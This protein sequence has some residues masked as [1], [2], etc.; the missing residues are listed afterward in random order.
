VASGTEARPAP[1]KVD[2][3]A[4][5]RRAL[6]GTG[7][8]TTEVS[9][10]PRVFERIT[11]GLYREPSAAIR[12]LISNAYDADATHVT[13][14][15]N[16]PIF[17]KIV[18]EDDGMGISPAAI[19][20]IVH[21]VGGSLKR[22]TQGPQAG[23][24]ADSGK[25]PKGRKLIGQMGIGLYSVA[26]LTRHF[27]I[28]TKQADS[29]YRI[30]LDIDLTGLDPSNLPEEG[31]ERYV[32]GY[33]KVS[34]ERAHSAEGKSHYTRITLHDVLPEARRIL[35]SVDRW[36][37]F[38][39]KAFNR[40]KGELKYHIGRADPKMEPNLPWEK[41][42]KPS[43]KFL[44]FVNA[45]S[46]PDE[47]APSSASL[48][49]TLDYYLAMLWRIS[50]SAPLRYVEDHPFS[51][52]AEDD[53]DFYDLADD[54]TPERIDLMPGETIGERVGVHE[55]GSS[56]TQFKVFID[57]VELRR[58][59]IF[60][61]FIPDVRKLLDRPKMFVGSFESVV[62]GAN[63]KGTGYFFWS[64]DIAPK[65]NNG[66]LVRV[67]GAS[68]TLFDRG[69]LDFRTSENLRLRQ[70]S[71]EAFVDTGLENALNVD[72]ES[73]VDSDPNYRALQRWAHRSMTRLFTR[74]KMD[75]KQL[76]ADKKAAEEAARARA[77]EQAAERIWAA[78]KGT[79][80]KRPPRVLVTTK[81]E[82]P[83][84]SRA[85]IFIGGIASDKRGGVEREQVF[86]ARLRSVVLVLDAWGLLD[87]LGDAERS[88]LVADLAKVLDRR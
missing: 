84:G 25:S 26:R 14:K 11:L 73:F 78:R 51:L 60:R 72:R 27:S 18:V 39:A 74:L 21:H 3:E 24:T 65:E 5:F 61:G 37:N 2:N 35:Q 63:L 57:D 10:D 52:T 69:F 15:M 59:V 86:S 81:S 9:T 79:P 41:K 6:T 1:P 36:Q 30:L 12:E 42:Q 54:G 44:S 55:R 22:S 87:D 31:A 53:I 85:D 46:T 7:S 13:V 32:A 66:I 47:S 70:V 56:P 82:E 43:E 33:A 40:T 58:P 76:G 23:V 48:D 49:Q 17:D 28:V 45:L 19:D 75:Q 64:Y 83:K 68:G 71:S 62:D 80:K 34:R 4:A 38:Y 88:A 77:A 8:A 67:A 16:P 29:P 50:L 20:Q